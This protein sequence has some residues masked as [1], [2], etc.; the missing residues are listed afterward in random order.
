M[1]AI[2][3]DVVL[4]GDST[5]VAGARVAYA[6]GVS[7]GGASSI[8]LGPHATY[9]IAAV[10]SSTSSLV[11]RLTAKYAVTS[12][13]AATSSVAATATVGLG[14]QAPVRYQAPSRNVSA[15]SLILDQVDLFMSDGHTRSQGVTVAD[16]NL[17]LF[18]KGSQID[19][20]LTDGTNV[21]DVQVTAGKVYW[22]EF[23]AG[24]YTIRFYPNVI[25]PWRLFLTYPT[26][27]QAVSLSYE[28]TP[29]VLTP[30]SSGLNASSIR[31]S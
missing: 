27:N 8:V 31:R 26:F 21:Q 22:T 23:L 10:L 14:F 16:L 7:L 28:V 12:F 11:P 15:G 2:S 5:V 30:V 18:F 1:S 25:G 9:K 17:K 3:I 24:F 19:W 13:L 29:K 20:P 6:V 4:A